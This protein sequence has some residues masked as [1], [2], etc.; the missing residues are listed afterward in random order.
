MPPA[1]P[2]SAAPATAGSPLPTGTNTADQISAALWAAAS[3]IYTATK[4]AGRV[5]AVIPTG[6]LASWADSGLWPLLFAATPPRL[7]LMRG[8]RGEEGAA[9]AAEPAAES[10]RR[11]ALEEGAA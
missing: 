5:F 10:P 6:L 9:P 7:R 1:A 2:P 4:G 8:I 3:S 11:H